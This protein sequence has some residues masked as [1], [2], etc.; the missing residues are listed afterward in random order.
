MNRASLVALLPALAAAALA[1]EPP[2]LVL[3]RAE[4]PV[5]GANVWLFVVEGAGGSIVLSSERNGELQVAR[6]DP[7]RP[8]A[9]PAW[10]TVARRGDDVAGRVA[11]HW[12]VYA[13]GRHW[14]AFSTERARTSYLLSLGDDLEPLG[15]TTVA[16][17]AGFPTNDLFLVAE[18]EGVAVGHFDPGYGHHV[19]RFDVRG[20][21]VSTARVGGGRFRHANGSSAIADGEGYRILA[22]ENL[23]SLCRSAIRLVRTDAEWKPVS[24]ETEW[25]E[26]PEPCNVSMASGVRLENGW[27]IVH[28][29]VRPGAWDRGELPPP[30][31]PAGVD[32]ED[33]ALVRYLVSPEGK[34]ARREVLVEEGNHPFRPHTALVG[35]RLYTTWDEEGHVFLRID[36]LE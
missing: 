35:D 16:D 26:E 34:V 11:D 4:A 29:R 10:R 32:P 36:R 6:F 20:R 2:K 31:A 13:H 12:H 27:W 33:G 30:R 23:M 14:L 25:I 24:V 7:D 9:R 21:A 19:F 18:P 5:D 22:T 15:L 28:A 3:E 1:D 17:E 8:G